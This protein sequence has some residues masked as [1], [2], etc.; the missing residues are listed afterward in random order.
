MTIDEKTQDSLRMLL[1]KQEIHEVLMRYCRG[2]DRCDEELLR[3]VYHPD[4]TDDHGMFTGKAA[5]FIP[6]ALKALGRDESTSHCIANELIE[7]QGDVAY[8]E[9]YFLAVHRRREKDGTKA[10][11]RFE[12]RYADRFERRQGGWKIA[13]RQVIFD[14]SRVDPVG[15]TF[16][17]EGFVCGKRSREDP[18]YLRGA[19]A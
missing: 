13:H 17:T 5:D 7:V 15:K 8:C 12:G 14:R 18:A 6:W 3:G 1:D 11:L 16:S 19:R 4:A 10:D 2:I 9:S